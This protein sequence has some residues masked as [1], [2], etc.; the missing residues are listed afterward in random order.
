[1]VLPPLSR[2]RGSQVLALNNLLAEKLWL[3]NCCQL[4]SWRG[5]GLVPTEASPRWGV[6]L[7]FLQLLG[8]FV[9]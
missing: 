9:N 3:L 4:G 7:E 2:G 8:S 1:M 5:L 6:C